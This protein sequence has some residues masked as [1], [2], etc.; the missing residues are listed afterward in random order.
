MLEFSARHNI[1]AQT[2]AMPLSQV[3]AALDRVRANEARYRVV[4]VQG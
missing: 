4:L 1:I 3:N 2:E